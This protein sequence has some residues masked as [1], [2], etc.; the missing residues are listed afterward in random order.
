MIL[1]L[2]KLRISWQFVSPNNHCLGWI[3][4]PIVCQSCQKFHPHH[5]FCY[6][7]STCAKDWCSQVAPCCSSVSDPSSLGIFQLSSKIFLNVSSL[8]FVDILPHNNNLERSPFYSSAQRV[9][10]SSVP[11]PHDP[12]RDA[13]D[14][15]NGTPCNPEIFMQI[16]LS[17][18]IVILYSN[19]N[20]NTWQIYFFS[21]I[22]LQFL[23]VNKYIYPWVL[24]FYFKF[25]NCQREKIVSSF[26]AIMLTIVLILRFDSLHKFV[27]FLS[28]LT[29]HKLMLRKRT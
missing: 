17:K 8:I 7:Y 20:I 6:W 16:F 12:A 29:L 18:V 19:I 10:G 9:V 25:T 24:E 3:S 21:A 11:I 1:I 15:K 26:Q 22:L 2:K 5:G 4:S 13:H 23:P 14:K 28:I 27:F